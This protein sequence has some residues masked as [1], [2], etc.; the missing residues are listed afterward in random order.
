M[1]Y[2]VVDAFTDKLFGGNPAC[3]CISEKL[4][5]DEIMQKIAFENNLSETAFI[6]KSGEN[7]NLRWFTP[8]FEIDLCGHATLAAAFILFN[9]IECNLDKIDF[10]TVSG[11]LSVTRKENLYEMTF[12]KR[13]A[14]NIM[15]QPDIVK[16]LDFEPLELYSERDLYVIMSDEEEV[17]NYIPDYIKLKELNSW[18]GIVITAKGNN[19]DFVSRYFCPELMAEDPVT[20]SAYSTL[21]PIWSNKLGKNRLLAKQLSQRGGTLYCECCSNNIKISGNAVIYSK[22]SILL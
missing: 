11:I 15:P 21:V 2:Y 3:I 9:H 20:G 6:Y 12:P 16:L 14:Q 10:E 18:L 19:V 22:G 1:D 17:K 13:I 4:L 7:Y 8:S 5:P